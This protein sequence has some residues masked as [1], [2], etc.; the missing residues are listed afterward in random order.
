MLQLTVEIKS[1]KLLTGGSFSFEMTGPF[2]SIEDCREWC[3]RWLNL[4]GTYDLSITG[5]NGKKT[6]TI[7]IT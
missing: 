6:E 3:L 5:P 1:K 2:P 7:A 4:L